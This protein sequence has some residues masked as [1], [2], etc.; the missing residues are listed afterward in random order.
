MSPASNSS[1]QNAS[2]TDHRRRT[3]QKKPVGRQCP[4]NHRSTTLKSWEF[5]K[6]KRKI[7]RRRPRR[8]G[9]LVQADKSIGA[10]CGGEA[11]IRAG[12]TAIKT[13]FTGGWSVLE[14]HQSCSLREIVGILPNGFGDRRS[15]MVIPGSE[16]V[17]TDSKAACHVRPMRAITSVHGGSTKLS[18]TPALIIRHSN[19]SMRARVQKT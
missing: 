14:V 13:L 5:P 15:G 12:E 19:A 18:K 4:V 10:V 2:R 6:N 16:Q 17:A 11:S 7:L 1:K 9:E 8:R 3:E